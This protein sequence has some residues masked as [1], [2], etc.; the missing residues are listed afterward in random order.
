[1]IWRVRVGNPTKFLINFI[2]ICFISAAKRVRAIENHL[3]SSSPEES[4]HTHT[5]TVLLT[6]TKRVAAWR[7]DVSIDLQTNF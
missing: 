3:I 4:S 1:M 2:S 7:G 5:H 6:E